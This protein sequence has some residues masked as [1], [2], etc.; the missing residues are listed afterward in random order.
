MSTVLARTLLD[1][2]SEHS[3]AWAE[4]CVAAAST[5][6]IP[7][8]DLA[9]G[10]ATPDKLRAALEE[11]KAVALVFY[12]HGSRRRFV[13]Q[14]KGALVDYVGAKILKGRLVYSMSCLSGS[15]LGPR[16]IDAGGLAFFGYREEFGFYIG[17]AEPAF[18]EPAN[19][20]WLRLAE[21]QPVKEALHAMTEKFEE[22]LDYYARGEGGDDPDAPIIASWLIHDRDCLVALG[23]MDLKLRDIPTPPEPDAASPW[24]VLVGFVWMILD[25]FGL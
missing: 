10:D 24:E 14:D 16:I 4:D 13:S 9:K 17:S 20:G 15:A 23:D 22:W 8:K 6:G 7:L 25:A 5:A 19:Q 3:F 21:G 18:R 1:E 12:D 2:A 11:G